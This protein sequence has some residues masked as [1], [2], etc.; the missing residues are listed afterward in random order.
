VEFDGKSARARTPLSE[1]AKMPA[2]RTTLARIG[3]AATLLFLLAGGMIVFTY[4]RNMTSCYKDR[5]PLTSMNVTSDPGQSKQLIEQFRKF[6]FKHNF[7]FDIVNPDQGGNDFRIRI[8]GKDAEIVTRKPSS[9]NEFRIE[10]YNTDCIH[11]TVAADIDD[12]VIDLKSFIGE[13]P[14]VA[15]TEGQ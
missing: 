8:L 2:N 6:A 12:L 7:R 9:P 4:Y 10:F 14:N 15:I 1:G 3:C 13:L 11:P 5:L